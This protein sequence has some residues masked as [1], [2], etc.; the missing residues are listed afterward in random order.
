MIDSIYSHSPLHTDRWERERDRD[1][2]THTVTQG[3]R[4][5]SSKFKTTLQGDSYHK[6]NHKIR[7]GALPAQNLITKRNSTFYRVHVVFVK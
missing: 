5:K 6:L 3:E 7:E 1:R 2:E 4:K